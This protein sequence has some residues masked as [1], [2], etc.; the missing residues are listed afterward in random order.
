MQH[1]AGVS[2]GLAA[3]AEYRTCRFLVLPTL[4]Q[5]QAANLFVFN[6]SALTLLR[7]KQYCC[8]GSNAGTSQEM[9][10]PQGHAVVFYGL[11]FNFKCT[12]QVMPLTIPLFQRDVAAAAS[13]PPPAL[14]Q[15]GC[16]V[17]PAGGPG[18]L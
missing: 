7:S 9:L 5:L 16:V 11:F 2:Q 14:L 4:E 17:L 3:A 8:V 6:L 12:T 13:C 15:P 1:A 10:I 18:V